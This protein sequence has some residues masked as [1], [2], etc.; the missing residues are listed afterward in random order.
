MKPCVFH[1]D[2]LFVNIVVHVGLRNSRK[3]K[4]GHSNNTFYPCGY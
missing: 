1:V 2:G 3:D 4:H